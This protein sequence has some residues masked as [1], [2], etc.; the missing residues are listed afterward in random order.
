[1]RRFLLFILITIDLMIPGVSFAQTEPSATTQAVAPMSQD[2]LPD[3]ALHGDLLAVAVFD[4]KTGDKT[5]WNN[6]WLVITGGKPTTRPL[7][8]DDPLPIGLEQALG[9]VL[10]I[11]AERFIY[12]VSIRNGN[13]DL[14]ICFRLPDGASEDA[15]NAWLRKN[16]PGSPGFEHEGAWLIKRITQQ[17]G[18][19]PPALP[20]SPYADDVR[21]ELNCWGNDVPVKVVYLTSDSMKKQ[22]MR[23]GPPPEAVAKIVD[24]YWMR[25]ISLHRRKTWRTPAG[26]DALGRA[27][28]G[29]G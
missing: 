27:G 11:G 7:G 16:I 20:V 21:Q 22:L 4:L 2:D 29:W 15:A 1:M 3:V 23:G 13:T 8:P 19:R 17:N 24:L 9:P 10:K 26:G 6:A 28:C 14:T 5:A 25:Q 18:A 12:A